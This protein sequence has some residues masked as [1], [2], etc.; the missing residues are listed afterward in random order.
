MY[1]LVRFIPSLNLPSGI[2]SSSD[3]NNAIGPAYS[4]HVLR[5]SSVET[6][7]EGG[8]TSST[9]ND[10]KLSSHQ[11]PHLHPARQ[12][13]VFR[14]SETFPFSLFLSSHQ[15]AKVAQRK[16]YRR[17]M[18]EVRQ[19][20]GVGHNVPLEVTLFM[21][22]WI[23]QM[24]K[25]KTI[26]VPTINALLAAVQSM[27]DALIS[28]ERIL[29]TPIPWSYNA[30]IWEVTW[31]YCLLLPFQL[32]GA[33]FNWVTVPAVVI[34]TYIVVGFAE[35]GSEIENPFAYDANDLNLDFFVN[36]IIKKEL[37][38]ITARPFAPPEDW[39]FSATNVVGKA[40]EGKHAAQMQ[41]LAADRV[42]EILQ[43]RSRS[44]GEDGMRHR[45]RS[46]V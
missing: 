20:G 14:W 9:S 3:A 39:V 5:Q 13:P 8:T 28:L 26:D 24:Q 42:R 2:P 30:H 7:I 34:T 15:K 46:P 43:N 40:G 41:Y 17:K 19:G 11:D 31:V 27:S 16:M 32:Y 36:D 21:S 25:R 35:I 12:P 18:K 23:A 45:A 44:T 29:T 38:A 22:C 33:G 10:E 6:D 1:H 4:R 37:D